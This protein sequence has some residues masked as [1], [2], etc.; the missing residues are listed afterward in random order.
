M[1]GRPAKIGFKIKLSSETSEKLKKEETENAI[2]KEAVSSSTVADSAKSTLLSQD[3][4]EDGSLPKSLPVPS[5][6]NLM[7]VESTPSGHTDVKEKIRNELDSLEDSDSEDISDNPEPSGHTDETLKIPNEPDSL[8]ESDSEQTSDNSKPTDSYAEHIRYDGE[9]AVYTDPVT[10]HEFIWSTTNNEWT[11]RYKDVPNESDNAEQSLKDNEN[12]GTRGFENDT[13]T[14][15]DQEGSV[16]VWDNDKKAWFP[17]VDDEFLANY[18]MSYGFI[19]NTTPDKD[20]VKEAEKAAEESEAKALKK[21]GPPDPPKWFDVSEEQ[22]TN[23]YVSNLPLDITEE[24]F[25]D[26]MQKCGLVMRDPATQKM[27]IKL[28]TKPN[29]NQLKGDALCTYIKIES[30]ELALNIIDG[31]TMRNHRLQVQKAQ[32]QMKGDYDPTLKPKKK[33]RKDKEKIKKMQEKLF[34]WRPEKFRGERSKH[35]K[36][37][38]IK[39]VFEPSLFDAE[40]QLILEYQQD[41]R[42]ECAKCGEVKKVVLYDRHPEGVAQVSMKEPEEADEVVKLIN[43][44]WF[45]KRQL[46]AE[47]WDGKTRYKMEETDADLN[48]RLGNWVDFL[49]EPEAKKKR[50]AEEAEKKEQAVNTTP[51][52]V[53]E[54]VMLTI[55][56][57]EDELQ[58]NSQKEDP[59]DAAEESDHTM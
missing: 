51:E 39:N 57:A 22:N 19:D 17:K 58:I 18:Q 7:E 45:G 52:V 4:P 12:S 9:V 37:V 13:H 16:Y 8:K 15:T 26:V 35:E 50:E 5:N 40:V 25:V 34:D 1:A 20:I 30:V 23:V 31:Y 36:V 14:Y 11:S 44:R 38:I 54:D 2:R 43:G 21:K 6:L 48:K 33:R 24:E 49:E 47:I 27:K 56:D 46:T 53:C 32:F 55:P 3:K 29:S 42:E 28:Y 59:Q 41:L 10:K